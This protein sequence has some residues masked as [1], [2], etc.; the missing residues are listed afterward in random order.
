VGARIAPVVLLVLA[1]GV[2][3]SSTA[4]AAVTFGSTLPAPS[5]GFYDA[6]TNACTAA[7]VDLPGAQQ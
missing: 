6:C 5:A 1:F 3:G 7:Q 4:A 2:S